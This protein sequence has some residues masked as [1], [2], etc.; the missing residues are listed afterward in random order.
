ME[1]ERCVTGTVAKHIDLTQSGLLQWECRSQRQHCMTFALYEGKIAPYCLTLLGFDSWIKE[2]NV[3]P[4]MLDL[5]T[6]KNLA[7]SK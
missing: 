2:R 1:E 3:E 5:L 7:C 4:G 6:N